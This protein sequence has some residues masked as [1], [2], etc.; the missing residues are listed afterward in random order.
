MRG[1]E[2]LAILIL[3]FSLVIYLRF[4]LKIKEV[5]KIKKDNEE[6][7]KKRINK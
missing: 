5:N 6:K 2:V 4:H 7:L 3:I 1:I